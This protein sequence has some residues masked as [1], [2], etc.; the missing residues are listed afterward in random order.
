LGYK[1]GDFSQT[2]PVTLFTIVTS[3]DGRT[4]AALLAAKVLSVEVA[5]VNIATCLKTNRCNK[6]EKKL[7]CIKLR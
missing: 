3:A 6:G 1:V 7:L 4:K 2:R 5:A